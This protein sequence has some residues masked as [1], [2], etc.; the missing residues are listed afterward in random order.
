MA[1]AVDGN[2]YVQYSGTTKDLPSITI[3]TQGNKA[4][5]ELNMYTYDQDGGNNRFQILVDGVVVDEFVSR[6]SQTHMSVTYKTVIPM[7][8]KTVRVQCRSIAITGIEIW[9]YLFS[10]MSL[11]R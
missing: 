8:N 3:N 10:V 1:E 4:I 6:T 9:K 5:V 2:N 7:P 11:K